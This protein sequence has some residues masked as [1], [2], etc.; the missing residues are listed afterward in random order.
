M[1]STVPE[2]FRAGHRGASHREQ[3]LNE[4]DQTSADSD[5]TLSDVDQTSADVDQASADSDQRAAD[6]DQA[7]S[8]RDLAAGT[9]PEQHHVSR[10]I[11][12]RTTQL[13]EDS[14]RARLEAA[15]E[16]DAV[17]QTRD[18][19]ALARD[20]AANARDLA[21]AQ[22]DAESEES[23][24]RA[25]FGVEIV[26][27]AAEHRKRAA[28]YRGFAA[29]HRVLAAEDRRAAAED[30]AQAAEERGRARVD[31]E[32]LAGVLVQAETDPLT[33][34]RSRAAG[35][36]DLNQEIER[37]RRT[38][39]PLVVALID[40][41]GLEAINDAPGHGAGDELVRQFAE[42]LFA[43]LGS[44]DLIIRLGGDQF[45]CAI[46]NVAETDVRARFDTIAAELA[47]APFAGGLRAGFAAMR[48]GEDP[49]ALIARADDE[50]RRLPQPPRDRPNA[51]PKRGSNGASRSPPTDE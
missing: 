6:R 10:E 13:R 24:G 37:C 42:L 51:D 43:R 46:S 33:G 47:A 2:P 4:T 40:L 14:A 39:S 31:R 3:S 38:N 18:L 5:Q 34:A 41:L 30:R 32:L 25:D 19:A 7:A 16:R 22:Q 15:R 11:R 49:G 28:E 17:A 27:R 21:M 1:R 8:D 29:K 36:A 12:Q 20:Q 50:L 45:L 23:G 9:D 35:L 44:Y 48:N 26:M